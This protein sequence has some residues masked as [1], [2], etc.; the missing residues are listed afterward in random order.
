MKPSIYLHGFNTWLLAVLILPVILIIYWQLL[1]GDSLVEWIDLPLVFMIYIYTILLSAP[2]FI[3]S[4]IGLRI[5]AT[6]TLPIAIALPVW[7][8]SAALSV[9]AG[10]CIDTLF[11]SGKINGSLFLSALPGII[12][13]S[14]VILVRYQQFRRLLQAWGQQ[15]TAQT[16]NQSAL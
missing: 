13:A 5:I 15:E 8:L 7:L 9:V 2:G 1:D 12:A 16:E 3:V 11:I 4:L 10:L 14:I 6:S